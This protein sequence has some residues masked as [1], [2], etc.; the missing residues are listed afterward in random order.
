MHNIPDGLQNF[1]LALLPHIDAIT[2]GSQPHAICK[3]RS[4][5]VLE[6]GGRLVTSCDWQQMKVITPDGNDSKVVY[7]VNQ[8]GKQQLELVGK[9]MVTTWCTNAARFE[10][11][12]IG[13]VLEAQHEA[14]EE[15]E[16]LFIRH[17]KCEEEVAAGFQELPEPLSQTN[18]ERFELA[19]TPYAIYYFSLFNE[20]QENRVVGIPVSLFSG[21]LAPKLMEH[22]QR[23]SLAPEGVHRIIANNLDLSQG[24]RTAASLVEYSLANPETGA[25]SMIWC[26]AAQHKERQERIYL[27]ESKDFQVEHW[28]V[29]HQGHK[30]L[31]LKPIEYISTAIILVPLPVFSLKSEVSGCKYG[32]IEHLL[33]RLYLT[34]KPIDM[35]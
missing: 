15:T 31:G 22:L 18:I 2:R 28:R 5:L 21:Q 25:V 24:F 16:D 17:L 26:D 27:P 30:V 33:D 4:V 19:A 3:T 12:T 23:F 7:L 35:D 34:E 9:K 13:E 32:L 29:S 1:L 11:I 8:K 14:D 6:R 20:E 10:F